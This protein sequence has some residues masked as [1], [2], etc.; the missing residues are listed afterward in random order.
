MSLLFI[1]GHGRAGTTVLLNALN[2]SPD[3]FLLGEAQLYR[4]GREPNFRERY[5]AMHESW[6]NQATKSSYAPKLPGCS[7][8]S[9]GLTYLE[10]LQKQYTLVGEKIVLGP[11][12]AGHDIGR[13]RDGMECEWRDARYV[14]ALRNP[15]AVVESAERLFGDQPLQ[16]IGSV[17]DTLLLF[18][19]S[20]RLLR[21]VAV[22]VHEH[23]NIEKIV[24]LGEWLGVDLN[25]GALLYDGLRRSADTY[26]EQSP[27]SE[28]LKKLSAIYN[29]LID[30]IGAG[31][32][33]LS[34]SKLQVE[35]ALPGFNTARQQPL[36]SVVNQLLVLKKEIFAAEAAAEEAA[37][38]E[39]VVAA[40]DDPQAH[41]DLAQVLIGLDRWPQA[42]TQLEVAARLRPSDGET[43]RFLGEAQIRAGQTDVAVET[44]D[45]S[46]RIA[47]S[48]GAAYWL[49]EG[50]IQT[51][52]FERA[53]EAANAATTM[54]SSNPHVWLLLAIAA[55]KHDDREKALKA[56]RRAV[57]LDP[58]HPAFAAHLTFLLESE[59]P[60]PS[61][62]K[63][64]PQP[65][66]KLEPK[67]K[68][69]RKPKI[70]SDPV[71][72]DDRMPTE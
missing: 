71:G 11:A 38:Y 56:A 47:P 59:T 66:P 62:P 24:R 6:G 3:V 50:F 1:V 58:D 45:K 44:L 65:D 53:V 67:P 55:A 68:P 36:G 28:F 23:V 12:Y 16:L 60:A 4:E 61:E 33:M 48:A 43:L 46:M 2:T 57:D 35:Q 22:V 32:I 30:E 34:P 5:N 69:K 9:D 8:A 54:D 41:F 25:E 40:P 10:A 70:S 17:I 26:I 7:E 27:F 19:H 72:N 14:F 37:L 20:S 49:A 31:E 64:E 42:L 52:Q 21:H 29:Q 18:V 51:K 63:L 13:L 15:A 39:G